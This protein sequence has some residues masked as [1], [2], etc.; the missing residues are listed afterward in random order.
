[1][2]VEFLASFITNIISAI[3]YP[4][5]FFLMALESMITPVPS[6]L[7]M[8]FAGFLVVKGVFD[9]LLV[10]LVGAIGSLAGS[11]FS[12][13][14][15]KKF[16]VPFVK[17]FGKWVLLSEKELEWTNSFFLKHGSKTI[18]IS[19]FIPA[20][21]HLISIPAGV[22]KMNLW[23]FSF[24]TFLG[25]FLWCLFLTYSGMYLGENWESLSKG[26]QG[27]DLIVLI[28]LAFLGIFFVW[29]RVKKK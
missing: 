25:S 19:R 2:L 28:I 8:P 4:G 18:F 11:L 10:S 14:L 1:M 9:P 15:G 3:G 20:V 22:A 23:L 29:T 21:R 27:I 12:Y 5:I 17:K 24:Y 7:V 6:E 26:M 13:Y 16:G